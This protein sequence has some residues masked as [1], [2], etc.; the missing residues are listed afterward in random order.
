MK[1]TVTAH[2][3]EEN[4]T[5]KLSPLEHASFPFPCA[6]LFTEQSFGAIEMV[7]M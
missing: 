1:T 2:S 3:V 7:V 5:P 6:F 4:P